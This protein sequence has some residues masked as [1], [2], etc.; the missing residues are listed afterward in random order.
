[1]YLEKSAHYEQ[2]LTWVE[3][4][5]LRVQ[6]PSIRGMGR[7]V[8]TPSLQARQRFRCQSMPFVLQAGPLEVKRRVSTGA[9]ARP[10]RVSGRA[11]E[12]CHTGVAFETRIATYS[13]PNRTLASHTE[14]PAASCPRRPDIKHFIV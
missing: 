13:C 3:P 12:F 1:M 9:R 11:E 8:A 2:A 5:E 6:I 10:R 4:E 14:A 7:M